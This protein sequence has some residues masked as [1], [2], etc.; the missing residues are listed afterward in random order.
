MHWLEALVLGILQGLT[1]FLPVSSSGHLE[2]GSYIFGLNEENLTFSIIVHGATFMSVVVVFRNDIISLIKA[3][4]RF[5]WDA[6]TRFILLLLLSA[7]PVGV[8]GVVFKDQIETLF[9][10]RIILVGCMLLVTATL[11]FLTQYAPPSNKEVGVKSALLIGIAQMVAIMPGISRAGATISTALYL[12]IDREK[13]TR[14]SFL[15]VLIP[16]F[17]A[18][19]LEIMDLSKVTE[20]GPISNTALAIGAA[21]AFISGLFACS[22]ML[23]IVKKGKLVYFSAYCVVVGIIAILA[24]LF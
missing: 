11:L 20:P 24:G 8:A 5:R 14:F 12:G 1:E 21:A 10:G 17:G 9:A 18:T 4:F 15:M 16:I 6:E 19:L 2:L 22:W 7:V 3:L 23:K 13:A